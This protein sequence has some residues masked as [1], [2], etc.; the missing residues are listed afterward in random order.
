MDDEPPKQ[1]LGNGKLWPIRFYKS[2]K[3]SR[4]EHKMS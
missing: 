2:Q 1:E 4:I 3:H